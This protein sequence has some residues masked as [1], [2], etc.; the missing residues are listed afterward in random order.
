M[1]ITLWT[2]TVSNIA[3]VENDHNAHQSFVV[4]S[5]EIKDGNFKL[6]TAVLRIFTYSPLVFHFPI[7]IVAV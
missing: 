3:F 7:S 6:S 1:S 4:S 2:S 5:G